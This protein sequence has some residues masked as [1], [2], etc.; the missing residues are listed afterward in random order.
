MSGSLVRIYTNE[1]TAQQRAAIYNE[2][3]KRFD[4]HFDT[5]ARA[6]LELLSKE[7]S[8]LSR[9]EIKTKL[10]GDEKIKQIMQSE[11]LSESDALTLVHYALAI[12]FARKF[13]TPA[14]G[15]HN[16]T[17]AGRTSLKQ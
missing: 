3:S 5:A 6:I 11:R 1:L 7:K 4:K 15:Q 2:T 14:F 8:G 13:V 16:I 10:V 12:L 9:E 17:D